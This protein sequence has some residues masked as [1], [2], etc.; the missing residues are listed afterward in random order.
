MTYGIKVKK[1]K[2]KTSFVPLW[3]KDASDNRQ[4]LSAFVA[5]NTDDRQ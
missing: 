2:K 1:K 3:E 4:H 5:V